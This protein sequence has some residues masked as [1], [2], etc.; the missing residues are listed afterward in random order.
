MFNLRDRDK[1]N[2]SVWGFGRL[3]LISTHLKFT[4]HYHR[5]NVYKLN[6]YVGIPSINYGR[7][8]VGKKIVKKTDAILRPSVC[9]AY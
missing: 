6:P 4:F 7:R 5:Y 9:D 3:Q 8:F 1:T 2:N